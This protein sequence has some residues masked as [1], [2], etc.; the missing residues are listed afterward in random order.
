[1]S[2]TLDNPPPPPAPRPRRPPPSARPKRAA[3]LLLGIAAMG[4]LTLAAGG[5]GAW[6]LLKD[7]IGSDVKESSWLEVPITAEIDDSPGTEG[8]FVNPKDFPPITTEVASEI[9]RAAKDERITG[10]YLDIESLGVGWGG[11]QELYDAV[12]EFKASGKPC[13]AYADAYDNKAYTLASACG[14]IYVAP[15][16]LIMAN[17][18]AISTEYYAGT[19]EKVGVHAQFEHVGDFKSAI[20]PY[21][22]TGPSDPASEAMNYMLDGI[23]DVMVADI[24]KGRGVTVEEAKAWI[25]DPPITPDTA[26]ARKMVDGA[27]FRDEVR[28]GIAGKERTKLKNYTEPN[29]SFLPGKRIAVVYTQGAIVSGESGSPLFGGKMIGDKTFIEEL[30]DLREDEDVVAVVLRVDSP[31]GSGLASD[32]MW[33]AIKRVQAEGKPVVVSMGDYAASG[34]YYI[35]APADWIVAQPATLTGSIGVFGGKMNFAGTYE[36][37]GITTYTWQRGALA[38]LFSSI[39]DF[40]DPERAKFREFLTSFYDAFL[41]R[42]AEGRKMDKAA[43]HEV[44]QGRVW[45]GNQALERKLVDQ[46]GGLDVAIAKARELA[47]VGDDEEI[48]IDRIPKRKSMMDQI[49]EDLDESS[50]AAAPL[51]A[52][53]PEPLR[54]AWS[55]AELLGRVLD[56]SGV[57]AMLPFEV[58]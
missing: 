5:V 52:E 19:L 11:V 38:G 21:V 56:G 32:N 18:F 6:F 34:G 20:E 50:S 4:L 26:L 35:S 51:V 53:I 39:S 7:R 42:V 31:G 54:D 30:D 29:V 37:V 17:G 49:L 9:R 25:D 28:E 24:A 22:R 57:A 16:G 58:R 44:A 27:K 8:M 23:Y 14:Q 43:V 40:S 3:R 48:K 45:T 46:V 33:R 12:A 10:L 1:M 36:K 15:A 13:A 47:K 55:H 2:D 41:G